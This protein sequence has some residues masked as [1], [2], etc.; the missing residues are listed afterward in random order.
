L[1]YQNVA[2]ESIGWVL[3]SNVVPSSELEEA[4]GG[5]LARLGMPR[6]QVEKLSGV[7]ERRWW[8]P[9]TAPSVVAAMA[10]EQ[11]LERAGMRP[12][13]VQALI[14]TSVSRDYLEPATSALVAGHMGLGHHAVSF[15]VT[16]ACVGFLNGMILLANMIE[17]GQVE[18]GVVVVGENVRAGVEATLKRLAAPT[19]TI[20]DFRENFAALTLGC[21]AA[22]VVMTRADQSKTTHRLRGAVIRNAFEHNQLC[23]GTYGEMRA[24]AHGLL[25]HG[26]GLACETWPYAAQ[27]LD[28]RK[29][30]DIDVVVGH[31]VSLAHFSEVFKRIEQPIEKALLTLP[32]LGN[33]GPASLPLTLAMGV[34]QGRVVPGQEVCMYGV[35]SGLGCIIMGV[36]W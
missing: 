13:Q 25:V 31:Q 19:A 27:E 8:E 21:G 22:A 34:A 30:D 3:P 15:D 12:D 35:G 36:Q 18:N 14:N 20:T 26:V 33:C 6:G 5:T 10:G 11:A 28:Y 4:F 9:G 32:Y 24:D 29:P 17:L 23:L 16:N 1:R 7:K 2:I